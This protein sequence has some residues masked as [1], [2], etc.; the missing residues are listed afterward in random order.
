MLNDGHNEDWTQLLDHL[1]GLRAWGL[2]LYGVLPAS[3][4]ALG[5]LEVADFDARP[6]DILPALLLMAAV[7]V[8]VLWLLVNQRLRSWYL[9]RWGSRI[10]A[11]FLT[12]TIIA[13]STAVSGAAGLIDGDYVWIG[14]AVLD[15]ANDRD[16]VTP[17]LRSLLVAAVTLIAT[18]TFFLTAVE[19]ESNLPSLPSKDFVAN[20]KRM[21]SRLQGL[22][23]QAFWRSPSERPNSAAVQ[24]LEE[25][26]SAAEEVAR[27]STLIPAAR[28]Y[29]RQLA[30]DAKQ[31]K[32]LCEQLIAVPGKW[33]ALLDNLNGPPSRLLND[34]DRAL[35]QSARRL[36]GLCAHV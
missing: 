12:V 2:I 31:L 21:R 24:A 34:H 13:L 36:L 27:D 9:T 4:A 5:F 16:F 20:I 11:T 26:C 22:H 19:D 14:L 30:E 35:R 33:H 3:L 1:V 6:R 23:Q 7:P 25:F 32:V 15:P 29:H 8:A 28:R 17:I 10:R 18:A